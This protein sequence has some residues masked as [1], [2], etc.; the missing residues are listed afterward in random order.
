MTAR[1]TVFAHS[2]RS[3]CIRRDTHHAPQCPRL[4][5]DPHSRQ[6]PCLR[7]DPHSRQRP[8]FLHDPKSLTAVSTQKRNVDIR[9]VSSKA[10]TA[11]AGNGLAQ[12]GYE[13]NAGRPVAPTTA[14][15]IMMDAAL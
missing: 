1:Q 9:H 14:I 2:R 8:C 5:H 3:P 4:R 10:I 13:V 11:H 12:L 7:H 15:F 6:S